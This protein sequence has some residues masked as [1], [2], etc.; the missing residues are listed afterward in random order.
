M[1]QR[2]C[3]AIKGLTDE[4]FEV[5]EETENID[6]GHNLNSADSM[7]TIIPGMKLSRSDDQWKTTNA[8]FVAALPIS[9]IYHRNISM[10]IAAMNKIVCNYF[11]DTFGTIDDTSTLKPI[12]IP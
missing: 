9:E 1:H 2:S 10:P 3:R 6:T 8:Y 11:H 5:L 4:T 12:S 7:P